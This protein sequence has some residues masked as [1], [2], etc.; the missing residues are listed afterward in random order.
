M[1]SETAEK[2]ARLKVYYSTRR[3]VGHTRAMILGAANTERVIVLA[4]NMRHGEDIKDRCRN[5]KIITWD[6]LDGLNG[7]SSPLLIDHWALM[8]IL[9]DAQKMLGELQEEN[10]KLVSALRDEKSITGAA[11]VLGKMK[12]ARKAKTSR[13]NGRKG[14]RPRR[15]RK[16]ARQK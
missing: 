9:S 1:W 7:E 14:G 10:T 13:E 4:H 3:G 8:E 11:T 15:V 2:I 16:D 5:A 12:S 6:R